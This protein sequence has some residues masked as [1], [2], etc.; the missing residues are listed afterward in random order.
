LH[1]HPDH[2]IDVVVDRFAQCAGL[3]PVVSRSN[4][5]QVEGIIAMAEIKKVLENHRPARNRERP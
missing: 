5:H 4:A 2:P 1:V 3:L